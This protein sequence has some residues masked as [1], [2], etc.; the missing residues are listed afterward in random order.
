[1]GS[2][3]PAMHDIK[4]ALN[5]LSRARANSQSHRPLL[6]IFFGWRW[7]WDEKHY[8]T[9]RAR[10]GDTSNHRPRPSYLINQSCKIQSV[11][12]LERIIYL[13][14]ETDN[15]IQDL[16]QPSLSQDWCTPRP[17]FESYSPGL[18]AHS[19]RYVIFLPSFVH[20]SEW[21]AELIFHPTTFTTKSVS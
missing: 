20:V 6:P 16:C 7:W 17:R 11:F 4:Y 1:M 8:S 19:S 13:Q 18:T 21:S 15:H 9:Q 10:S 12:V 14:S 5:S 2:P 3:L